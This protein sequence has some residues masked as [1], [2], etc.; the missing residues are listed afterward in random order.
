MGTNPNNRSSGQVGLVEGAHPVER[1]DPGE[2]L[3]EQLIAAIDLEIN[4][5]DYCTARGAGAT[6]DECIEAFA[7]LAFPEFSY[8]A[9]FRCVGGTHQQALEAM[10]QDLHLSVIISAMEGGVTFA[11]L[12]DSENFFHDFHSYLG[13]RQRGISHSEA[14][15]LSERLKLHTGNSYFLLRDYLDAVDCGVSLDEY[16]E[17]LLIG[18]ASW[19]YLHLRKQEVPHR[20]AL[21]RMERGVARDLHAAL[22]AGCSLE[23]ALAAE[24]AGYVLNS[25][26]VSRTNG[27]T[28][29]ECIEAVR[30]MSG[31]DYAMARRAGVTHAQCLRIAASGASLYAYVRALA[32]S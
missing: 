5:D 23:E 6:H 1:K 20:Q 11:E 4:S 25:Y 21:D 16:C 7:D 27:A 19:D 9:K 32:R 26:V 18:G 12:L 28:H 17:A 24:R 15:R 13:V 22:Q 2:L 30:L 31:T 3:V 14:R 8:Y 10:E 29:D